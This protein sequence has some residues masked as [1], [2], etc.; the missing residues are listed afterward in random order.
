MGLLPNKMCTK[1]FPL[2]NENKICARA[3]E[4]GNICKGDSGNLLVYFEDVKPSFLMQLC[5]C[6]FFELLTTDK[7]L[8]NLSGF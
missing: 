7:E 4:K 3:S 8:D 5:S 2:L 1:R 6:V